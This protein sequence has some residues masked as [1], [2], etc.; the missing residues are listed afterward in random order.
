MSSW[1]KLISQNKFILTVV[2]GSLAFLTGDLSLWSQGE[3][4]VSADAALSV[5]KEGPGTDVVPAGIKQPALSYWRDAARGSPQAACALAICYERGQ[6]VPS[7]DE[8]AGVWL[9]RAAQSDFLPAFRLMAEWDRRIYDDGKMPFSAAISESRQWYEKGALAGD[10]ECQ[11]QLG[12]LQLDGQGGP[13]DTTEGMEWIRVA[14]DSGYGPGAAVLASI[15]STNKLVPQD[16]PLAYL[17]GR[18]GESYGGLDDKVVVA[19]KKIIKDTASGLAPSDVEWI[20]QRYAEIVRYRKQFGYCLVDTGLEESIQAPPEGS[21]CPLYPDIQGLIKVKVSFDGHDSHFFCIDTGS[22]TSCIDPK[23]AKGLNLNAVGE[24][25]TC[26]GKLTQSKIYMASGEV[27]G[28]KFNNLRLLESEFP[29]GYGCE[30]LLGGNF[31]RHLRVKLDPQNHSM[32]LQAPSAST[33]GLPLTFYGGVPYVEARI[34]G[35]D[36]REITDV[37]M[38][39]TGNACAVQMG[40]GI[41]AIHP[42]SSLVQKSISQSLNGVIAAGTGKVGRLASLS[43]GNFRVSS[44]LLSFNPVV[45]ISKFILGLQILARFTVTIDYPEARL[46]LVPYDLDTPMPGYGA[47]GFSCHAGQSVVA[48]VAPGSPAA[49]AGIQKGDILESVDGNVI[50]GQFSDNSLFTRPGPHKVRVN[51]N[52]EYLVLTLIIEGV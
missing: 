15:Y 8:Q 32:T 19:N 9:R 47:V 40:N 22:S 48:E 33:D 25:A 18:L 35:F 31:L 2:L 5:P 49:S 6:G 43:L 4:R 1:L 23:V 46:G 17:W 24:T 26:F 52:G 10:P 7:D 20:E 51:R 11:I 41:N 14:A 36:H 13:A 44:P 3:P 39:D 29:E 16:L 45:N 21:N 28:V 38:V 30:G 42:F 27:G 50:K 12:V 37:A 34:E